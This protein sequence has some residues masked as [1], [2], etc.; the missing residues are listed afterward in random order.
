MGETALIYGATWIFYGVI[1]YLFG[2]GVA[3]A[4]ACIVLSGITGF[5]YGVWRT[6]AERKDTSDA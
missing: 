4:V 6:L 5:L 3:F 1:W 2:V